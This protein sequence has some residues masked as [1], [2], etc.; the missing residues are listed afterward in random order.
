MN[1]E[2]VYSVEF[3]EMYSIKKVEYYKN[4]ECAYYVGDK[5]YILIWDIS[6]LPLVEWTNKYFHPDMIS[7][8]HANGIYIMRQDDPP[9]S[10]SRR[11]SKKEEVINFMYKEFLKTNK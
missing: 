3:N 9:S 4:G 10:T 2:I 11:I 1:S 8:P 7:Y 5:V 6:L